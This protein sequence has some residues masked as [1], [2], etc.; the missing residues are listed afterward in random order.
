MELTSRQI[1]E[2]ARLISLDIPEADLESIALRLSSLL[3]EMQV[4]EHEL[5]TLMD[6]TEPIPPVYPHEPGD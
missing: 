4:I 3:T 5:G 6:Q 1:R 2:M